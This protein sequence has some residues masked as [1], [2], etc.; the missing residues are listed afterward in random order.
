[1][2]TTSTNCAKLHGD[3]WGSKVMPH[4]QVFSC[5]KRCRNEEPR[6]RLQEGYPNEGRRP[7]KAKQAAWGFHTFHRMAARRHSRTYTWCTP[8][9]CPHTDQRNTRRGR[10]AADRIVVCFGTAAKKNF[11]PTWPQA[12]F[13]IQTNCRVTIAFIHPRDASTSGRQY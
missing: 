1:M 10:T 8:T 6:K 12:V 13:A 11:H 7:A 2:M 9:S 5:H 4:T 3:A